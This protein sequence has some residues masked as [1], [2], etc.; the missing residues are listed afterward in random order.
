MLW[1]GDVS[2]GACT[3]AVLH[4]LG[5]GGEFLAVLGPLHRAWR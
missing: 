3:L 4:A 1:K 2:K 5:A